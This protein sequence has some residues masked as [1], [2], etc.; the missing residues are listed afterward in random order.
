MLRLLLEHD[1]D[2]HGRRLIKDQVK[3]LVKNFIPISL[4]QSKGSKK[5]PTQE[6]T[7]TPKSSDFF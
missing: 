5:T 2:H 3:I 6:V 1:Y 7:E 4:V